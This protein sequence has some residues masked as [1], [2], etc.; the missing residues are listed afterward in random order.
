MLVVV[1][2]VAK[3]VLLAAKNY[4]KRVRIKSY[5]FFSKDR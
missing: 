4:E 2:S 5:S 1:K 3:D